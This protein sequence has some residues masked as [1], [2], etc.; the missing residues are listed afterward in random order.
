MTNI[1]SFLLRNSSKSL[2]RSTFLNLLLIITRTRCKWIF[3]R[4]I[5]RNYLQIQG[6]FYPDITLDERKYGN[7]KIKKCQ[8]NWFRSNTQSLKLLEDDQLKL[9][10]EYM[11]QLN[12]LKF[13]YIHTASRCKNYRNKNLMF[14][15]FSS[16]FFMFVFSR[17]WKK[18][19]AISNSCSKMT[20]NWGPF[21]YLSL[22]WEQQGTSLSA[23]TTSKKTLTNSNIRN[24]L[25]I[26]TQHTAIIRLE[27][28]SSP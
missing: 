28:E 27:N 10:T 14:L 24:L 19:S 12:Y 15:R 22:D 26:N 9:T 11:R 7:R 5:W 21:N 23:S 17:R 6:L 13:D 20:W 3:G 25:L 4:D 18:T 8:S 1:E 16:I 2:S